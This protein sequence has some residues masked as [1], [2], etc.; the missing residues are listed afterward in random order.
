[1]VLV[2]SPNMPTWYWVKKGRKVIVGN[3]TGIFI[4]DYRKG[5]IIMN[6]SKHV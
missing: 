2:N 1:V 4:H 6:R 3:S 5:A